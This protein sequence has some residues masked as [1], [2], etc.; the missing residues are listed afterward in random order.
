LKTWAKV[1]AKY[2][3]KLIRQELQDMRRDMAKHLADL[4]ARNNDKIEDDLVE[5]GLLE[6]DENGQLHVKAR[7]F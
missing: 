7:S 2:L 6:R 4:I 1:L 3:R 5:L